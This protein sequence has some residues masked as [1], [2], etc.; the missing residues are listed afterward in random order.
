MAE[1]THCNPNRAPRNALGPVVAH[2]PEGAPASAPWRGRGL[3]DLGFLELDVLADLRVVLPQGE[4][5]GRAA[6]IL[7]GRVEVPGAGRAHELDQHR[8]GLGHDERSLRGRGEL[9]REVSLRPP[10]VKVC[11]AERWSRDGRRRPP[12]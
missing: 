4:L 1:F 2:G 11:P 7:L 8:S 5:L 3:L 9:T 6:R 12:R 10:A